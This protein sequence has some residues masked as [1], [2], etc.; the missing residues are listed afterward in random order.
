MKSTVQHCVFSD[1]THPLGG[2]PLFTI[3]SMPCPGC[4]DGAYIAEMDRP[5]VARRPHNLSEHPWRVVSRGAQSRFTAGPTKFV[6]ATHQPS[7][8][9]TSS[10]L[11]P[12]HRLGDEVFI[13]RRMHFLVYTLLL[14]PAI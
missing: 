12:P 13:L 4:P 14:S 7:S 6:A 8:C 5:M 10:P 2:Q 9:S 11:P 1:G 3:Y